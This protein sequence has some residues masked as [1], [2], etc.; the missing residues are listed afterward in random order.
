L[1]AFK[2]RVARLEAG[3]GTAALNRALSLS[4]GTPFI[5]RITRIQRVRPIAAE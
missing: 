1:C 2:T 3:L 4:D 5:D